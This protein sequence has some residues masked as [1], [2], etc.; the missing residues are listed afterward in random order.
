M[1]EAAKL[2]AGD[3]QDLYGNPADNWQK[4]AEIASAILGSKVLTAEEC[5]LVM[6]AVKLARLSRA[7]DHRDSQIDVAGYAWVLSQVAK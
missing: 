6:L 7:P 3:R 2:T 4:V 1:D 5:V